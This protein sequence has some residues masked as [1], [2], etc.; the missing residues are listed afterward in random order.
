MTPSPPNATVRDG[1]QGRCEMHDAV[2]R[3]LKLM[4]DDDPYGY[5]ATEIAALQ[6]EAANERLAERREQVRV[7][8]QRATDAGIDGI[9]SLADIVPLLF[10]HTTYK[11]YPEAFVANGNWSGMVSWLRALSALPVGSID[12]DGVTD[13]DDWLERLHAAGHYVISSSGTSGKCS[14]LDQSAGDR[15]IT[16]AMERTNLRWSFGIEALQDRAV[17]VL[18]PSRG[19]NRFVDIFHGLVENF[20]RPGLSRFL[21]DEP[22]SVVAAN[23]FGALRRAMAENRATPSD[24]AEAEA[25]AAERQQAMLADLG[26]LVDA[27]CAARDQPAI[28]F[29]TWLQHWTIVQEALAR[30]VDG[31]GF[32]PETVLIGGGGLKGAVVP[33]DH[34]E[35]IRQFY[36]IAPDRLED[37]YGMSEGSSWFPRCSARRYHCP[38]W[39]VLLVLDKAGETLLNPPVGEA[40]TVDGRLAF[41]DLT[42][43]GRWGGLISGDNVDVVFGRCECGRDG[44]AVARIARYLDLP[45]GDDKLTCAGTI[46]G[47]VRGLMTA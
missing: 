27:I 33:A 3:L 45:E 23:R 13:V 19:T 4:D 16:R 37:I 1:H 20:G 11:S 10:A 44:P 26:S 15:Q 39:M 25:F 12:L 21:S 14:F 41:L 24:L 9:S 38:P 47:Y 43:E 36:G 46:D 5:P 32:H 18:G 2:S 34:R 42:T 28:L 17:F 29:G 6:L 31:G 30:G 7:L 8:S 35:Q 22:V 40:A